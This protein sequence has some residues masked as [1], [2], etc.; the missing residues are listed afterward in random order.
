MPVF[1]IAN[2]DLLARP[3]A[4]TWFCK[5]RKFR[6]IV[7]ICRFKVTKIPRFF[8]GRKFGKA[9][10]HCRPKK[11]LEKPSPARF[12][13][14]PQTGLGPHSGLCFS[15]CARAL[16]R[17]PAMVIPSGDMERATAKPGHIC[18]YMQ[19][20]HTLMCGLILLPYPLWTDKI[21]AYDDLTRETNTN[22]E[23]SNV[24]LFAR[25]RDM[26]FGYARCAKHLWLSS[27]RAWTGGHPAAQPFCGRLG[28]STALVDAILNS[29]LSYMRL[30]FFDSA[31]KG[32]NLS[33]SS[34]RICQGVFCVCVRVR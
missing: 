31:G 28:I 13:Q 18:I 25:L 23:R 19:T 8:L 21:F 22:F 29:S 27:D 11:N 30:V 5:D 34:I 3:R 6:P 2:L 12:C 33:K 7:G 24:D 26:G 20:N 4:A 32:Q 1:W 17:I 10:N 9:K 14:I 15:S 16:R